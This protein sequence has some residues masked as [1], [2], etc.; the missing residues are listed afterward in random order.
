MASLQHLTTVTNLPSGVPTLGTTSGTAAPFTLPN[1]VGVT[2]IGTGF[3]QEGGNLTGGTV[4]SMEFRL[5]TILVATLS[6]ISANAVALQSLWT[7][8]SSMR[9]MVASVMTGADTYTGSNLDDTFYATLGNDSI[10][11]GLGYDSLRY[12][13]SATGG[14][15]VTVTFDMSIEGAGTAT[16]AGKVDSFLGIESVVG[17]AQNDLFI[18]GAGRQ[19]FV[20]QDGNDEFRGGGS[21]FDEIDYR[22]ESG[23]FGV[24]VNLIAGTATDT[25]NHIDT[26]SGIT[27]IRGSNKADTVTGNNFDNRLRGAGGNDTVYGGSG[28]DSLEGNAGDDLLDGGAFLNDRVE[29]WLPFNLQ[30]EVSRTEFDAS[31]TA[32]IRI[33]SATGA[34][35]DLF[36]VKLGQD[37]WTVT[38]LN[39]MLNEHGTDT[40]TFTTEELRV[41]TQ[42]SSGDVA[43][44]FKMQLGA[45]ISFDSAT[46]YSI[47]G[48][49]RADY[50]DTGAAV[51]TLSDVTVTSHLGAGNDG[52]S[53]HSGVDIAFGEAGNDRLFGL[54]GN[55][56]LNGGDGNDIISGGLGRDIL[57]GGKGKD[58]FVLDFNKSPKSNLDTFKDFKVKDDNIWLENGVMTKLPKG[59]SLDAPKKLAEKYIAFASS[60]QDKNDRIV[61]D[62]DKGA[63]YYDQDG[64]GGKAQVQIAQFKKGTVLGVS[65]FWTV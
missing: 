18:G 38:G 57:W 13:G 54:G 17:T 36:R 40:V 28:V 35:T 29:Y 43:T 19:R 64:V 3:A 14:Q 60:A 39:A 30:G 33:T 1:G 45:S 31:G 62:K 32:T 20:G 2:F 10:D 53:G 34:A 11:G 61:Y 58:A 4:T 65:D 26:L 63:L 9:D 16:S 59:G 37:G 8:T 46:A 49:I 56:Q 25:Y 5:N 12:D 52:L 44:S 27:R 7:S 22:A 6:G 15:G 21:L 41:Y 51:G 42:T 55:D 24:T 47:Q 23:S 50:V 48:S